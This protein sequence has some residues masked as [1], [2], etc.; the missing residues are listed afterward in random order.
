MALVGG[1][2]QITRDM[3]LSDD[4][5]DAILS[6]YTAYCLIKAEAAKMDGKDGAIYYP[7]K[8]QDHIIDEF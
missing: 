6:A 2:N 7:L 1:L 8:R 5:L 3:L 4:E